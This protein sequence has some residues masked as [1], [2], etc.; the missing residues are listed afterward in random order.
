M[1][2]NFDALSNMHKDRQLNIFIPNI[3][4]NFHFEWQK[5]KK[6]PLFILLIN[7]K[8]ILSRNVK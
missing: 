4:L 7:Y 6:K 5:E 1:Y 8:E 2:G 3:S